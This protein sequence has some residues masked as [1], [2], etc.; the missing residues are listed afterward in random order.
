MKLYYFGLFATLAQ[1]YFSSP[2][3]KKEDSKLAT[4][5]LSGTDRCTSTGTSSVWSVNCLDKEDRGD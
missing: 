5:K 4:M 3:P 2:L 1:F